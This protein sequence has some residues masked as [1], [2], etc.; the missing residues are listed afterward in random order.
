MTPRDYQST[1]SSI[2]HLVIHDNSSVHDYLSHLL[3][4]SDIAR[5]SC[6]P[7][8]NQRSPGPVSWI[9]RRL[10]TKT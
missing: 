8:Y 4:I 3:G 2:T 7:F 1:N 6:N 9:H 10:R 5:D